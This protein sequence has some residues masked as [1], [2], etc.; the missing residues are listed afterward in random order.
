MTTSEGAGTPVRQPAAEAEA[1]DG[2]P[3]SRATANAVNAGRPETTPLTGRIAA[4]TADPKQLE[5]E[6][7]RTREQLCETMQELAA[8]VDVKS[9]TRAKAAEVSGR[10][11]SS[12]ARARRNATDRAGNLRS[13][14]ASKTVAA[15]QKVASAGAGQ[16]DQLRNQAAKVGAPVW[17]AT[18][19]QVRRAVTKG[20]NGARERW[21]PIALAA[22]VLIAGCLAVRQWSK[23]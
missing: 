21:V 7:E 16:R 9:R 18:P 8:R 20:A 12:T 11:K 2:E 10:M 4:P 22:G 17:E 23:R 1:S 5:A 13:Q 15:R 3:S 6:I 14:V 19:E